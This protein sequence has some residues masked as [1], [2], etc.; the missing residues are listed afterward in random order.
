ML[1]IAA[2]DVLVSNL[3]LF[4]QNFPLPLALGKLLEVLRYIYNDNHV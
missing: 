4:S 2:A 3:K 1:V